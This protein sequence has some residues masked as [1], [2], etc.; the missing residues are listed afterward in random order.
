MALAL[1]V[2]EKIRLPFS[3]P[4]VVAGLLLA[5]VGF[6]DYPFRRRFLAAAAVCAAVAF[7][8]PLGVAAPIRSI[9]FAAAIAAML[10]IVAVG[11]HRLLMSARRAE[12]ADVPEPLKKAS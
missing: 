11:D 4:V 12:E 10:T 2:Q 6:A 3:L 7:L 8:R 5:G 1:S 9:L